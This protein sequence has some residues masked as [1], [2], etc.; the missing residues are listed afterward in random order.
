MLKQLSIKNYA[1]IESLEMSPSSHL[2]II[3]GETGAGK[4]IMLGAVGL[5]LGNR[6]D[7][8][9]LFDEE[10]K[11]VI[12]GFFD[13]SDYALKD[14]F[15]EE[16]LGY[17]VET[18]IRREISPSGK[19]RAFV[20]D[21]PVTLD[22]LKKLGV[23]L[24]DVHSQHDH[25][26][27]GNQSYQLEVVDIFAANKDI[28]ADYQQKYRAFQSAQKNYNNLLSHA[29]KI[30]AEADFN[31]F[32]YEE[33]AKANLQKGEE[34]TLQASLETLENAEEIKLKLNEC[35]EI[36]EKSEFSVMSQL[37]HAKQIYRQLERFG[38]DFSSLD[39]RLASV[40]IELEDIIS[41]TQKIEDKISY[42]P[43]LITET[44]E[45]LSTIFNLQQKHKCATIEELLALQQE[46]HEKVMLTE[47]LDEELQSAKKNLS[48]AEEQLN[49]SGQKL[50]KTR[51]A[52]LP[53]L[54]NEITELLR[55]LGMPEAVFQVER[56]GTK[57]EKMGIDEVNFLFSANKG[58][59]PQDIR[60]VASGGEFS[61]LMFCIKFILADKTALP[62]I[63]FDEIDT[64]VSGEVAKKMVGMMKQ[65][66][67]RHQVISI[68]HLPQFAAKGDRHF[69]VYKD[70]SQQRTVSRIKPLEKEERIIEIAKMIDGENP[71]QAALQSARELLAS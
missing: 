66:A 65:M 13:V 4:S 14:F 63:I 10:K 49:I 46:L 44:Q 11:C 19:S 55:Q 2:N 39:K 48:A 43:E 17:E 9:V 38:G 53:K 56:K 37:G 28:L 18:I 50:T 71:S 59:A 20:N 34:E 58:I 36:L 42:D 67:S 22:I 26:L 69:F 70:N 7:T 27:L 6:A 35:L 47:N 68:S 31:Q 64:G 16:D 5:L 40:F 3:T 45:R 54:T 24:M 32:Q 57:P 33:L 25:L 1:L 23:H 60:Q 21:T 8:K 29:D 61:R 52:I 30:R 12:E 62:T 51:E 41:E 15:D